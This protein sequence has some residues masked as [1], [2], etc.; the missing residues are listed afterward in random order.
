MAISQTP[1]S[2]RVA[3]ILFMISFTHNARRSGLICYVRRLKGAK[4]IDLLCFIYK[5]LGRINY[6]AK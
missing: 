1:I 6:K 4:L 2:N 3:A 5:L